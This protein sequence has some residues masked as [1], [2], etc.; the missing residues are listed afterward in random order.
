MNKK[1]IVLISASIMVIASFSVVLYLNSLPF[2][3]DG[4]LMPSNDIFEIVH[5]AVQTVFDIFVI[6]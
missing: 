2:T 4:I 3:K 5:P 6:R 1:A